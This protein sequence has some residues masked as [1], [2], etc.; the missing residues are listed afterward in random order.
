MSND[1]VIETS[2]SQKIRAFVQRN[3]VLLA[4]T[5]TTAVGIVVN[6]IALREHEEFLKEKGLYD[7]FCYGDDE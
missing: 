4:V 7:E 3:K 1:V 2:R 6:K 5:A